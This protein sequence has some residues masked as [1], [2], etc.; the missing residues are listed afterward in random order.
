MKVRR[1]RHLSTPSILWPDGAPPPRAQPL[2]CKWEEGRG[3]DEATTDLPHS[4]HH[5]QGQGYHVGVCQA[6]RTSDH[7]ANH[8]PPPAD[9]PC[10][11]EVP[12]C[13]RARVL[14]KLSWRDPS[15]LLS[16]TA[17]LSLP[18]PLPAL[19]LGIHTHTHQFL[20][21]TALCVV[22]VFALCIFPAPPPPPRPSVSIFFSW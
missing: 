17:T 3:G 14:A 2:L 22:F 4:H 1:P 6:V 13:G 10:T 21:V 16:F 18:P 8:K 7:P 9:P 19:D 15:P 12:P 20:L 11:P 5:L